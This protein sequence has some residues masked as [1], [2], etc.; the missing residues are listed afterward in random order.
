MFERVAWLREYFSLL[1]S[2]EV[3]KWLI[4]MVV[5]FGFYFLMGGSGEWYSPLGAVFS[6][7]RTIGWLLAT[8]FPF[9]IGS[10]LILCSDRTRNNIVEYSQT[11]EEVKFSRLFA[12]Y[13]VLILV[14][15]ALISFAGLAIGVSASGNVEIIGVLPQLVG[16]TLLI[17]LF[18]IPV[19]SLF[20]IEFDSMSKSIVIGFFIS[21]AL[22]FST[23][24][25]G[26][27]INYA[28]ISFFGPAHLLSAMLFIAIGAY[29]NYSVDY[30]VGTAYQPIHLVTPLLVWSVYAIVSYLKARGV[31]YENLSRWIE[32][33]D[34]WLASEQSKAKVD[35]ST[36]PANLSAIRKGLHKRQRYALA[37]S[38][39]MILLIAIGG[40]GYIQIKRGELTQVVYESPSEG[41]SIAIG[42]W[43]YGSFTGVE[44][45]SS[46]ITMGVTCQ[47]RILDWSGGAGYVYFTFEHRDMT[48]SEFQAL[49]E[50]EF[51]DLFDHSENGN[52]G[53]IGTFGGGL[54]GP[55]HNTEYV[56]VLRF[57]D[58]NGRTS[59]DVDIWFQVIITT[60]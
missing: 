4:L 38:I 53:V 54:S 2:K 35:D 39:T 47:G 40:F 20:A 51:S 27:P 57:N 16:I 32:E 34:G 59:G 26:F 30:Y 19:Y 50:T 55:I 42:D 18:L 52:Y 37:V 24:Q 28:E 10:S 6:I 46:S 1:S 48:W 31:F 9:V 33:R 41:E 7:S 8:G 21:I 25:P 23:G 44:P 58:V 14:V 11:H 29:G 15:M 45:P 5:A 60:F 56:W 36:L 12:S 13:M 17:S 3:K 49:N 22:V 43:L